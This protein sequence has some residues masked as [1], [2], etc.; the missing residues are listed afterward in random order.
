ML[1]HEERKI[2]MRRTPP[3]PREIDKLRA[4]HQAKAK[5][6]AEVGLVPEAFLGDPTFQELISTQRNASQELLDAAASALER[7]ETRKGELTDEWAERL[8]P[9]FFADLDRPAPQIGCGLLDEVVSESN[10]G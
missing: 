2:I 5:L 4:E 3:S 9:T 1:Y 8:A 10:H 7:L 6:A